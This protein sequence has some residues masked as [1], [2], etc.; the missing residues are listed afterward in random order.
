MASTSTESRPAFGSDAFPVRL[1][2]P[3]KTQMQEILCHHEWHLWSTDVEL[4][5]LVGLEQLFHVFVKYVAVEL[6]TPTT[7]VYPPSDE[8]STQMMNKPTATDFYGARKR[9]ERISRARNRDIQEIMI[10]SL[11]WKLVY[12]GYCQLQRVA[13]TA[14]ITMNI[15]K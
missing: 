15:K 6:V 2:E 10:I 1:L 7:R 8:P 3:S 12:L 4:H 13:P 11:T 14:Q 5:V 9:R